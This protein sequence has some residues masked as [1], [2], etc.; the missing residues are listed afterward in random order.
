MSETDLKKAAMSDLRALSDRVRREVQDREAKERRETNRAA[1]GR[2][3]KYRNSYSCPRKPSDY[4]FLYVRVTRIDALGYATGWSFQTDSNGE[5][6][7]KAT[8]RLAI[9]P[10]NWQQV[11]AREFNRAWTRFQQR[12]RKISTRN[13]G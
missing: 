7:V 11:S 6:Q 9:F 2:C 3:F 5:L 8:E 1:I 10:G 13:R 12:L 4:W